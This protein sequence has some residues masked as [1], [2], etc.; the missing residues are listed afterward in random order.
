MQVRTVRVFSISFKARKK[1]QYVSAFAALLSN[2]CV[3]TWGNPCSGGAS[4]TVQ[5]Q[6]QSVQGAYANG[7]A[8]AAILPDSCIVT[9]GEPSF[10]GDSASARE[11]ISFS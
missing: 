6:L 10:G 7:Y 1:L 5:Q 8:F 9:W 2:G 3:V 11:Q 4:S